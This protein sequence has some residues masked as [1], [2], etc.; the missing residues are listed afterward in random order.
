MKHDVGILVNNAGVA[1]TDYSHDYQIQ[2]SLDMVNTN[3][4]SMIFMS[5]YFLKH[6]LKRKNESG[7]KSAIIN[8]SSV[9]ALTPV[10]FIS[11]YAGTKAFNRLYS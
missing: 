6:F 9:A 10:T 3:I 1:I 5:Q 7:K 2:K 11:I 4:N 8:Y